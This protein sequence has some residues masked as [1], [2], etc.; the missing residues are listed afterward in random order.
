MFGRLRP[1]L[2]GDRALGWS[3]AIGLE[4]LLPAAL[5]CAI[6]STLWMGF[7][8]DDCDLDDMTGLARLA[9]ITT[10]PQAV[11]STPRGNR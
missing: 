6:A 5:A 2:A 1:E 11:A 4:T 8:F 3:G 7:D 10:A 9:G